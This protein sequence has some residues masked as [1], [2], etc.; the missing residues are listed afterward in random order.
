[1]IRIAL[2]PGDGGGEEV[3][4]GPSRLLQRLADEGLVDVTG[5]WPV[6]AR[7]AAATGEVLPEETLAA[8]DEA[9]AILLG[10]VG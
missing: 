7:A 10:A 4:E 1:M 2:L 3:L 5:P 9:D 6:G 8:C